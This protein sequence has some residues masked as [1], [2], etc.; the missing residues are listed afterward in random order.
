[1]FLGSFPKISTKYIVERESHMKLA[2]NYDRFSLTGKFLAASISVDTKYSLPCCNL[3]WFF[4]PV[5][6][7]VSTVVIILYSI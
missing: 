6:T 2:D 7:H 1:M 5:V 4:W 3:L